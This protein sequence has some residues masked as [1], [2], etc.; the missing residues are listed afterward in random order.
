MTG[1]GNNV[2]PGKRYSVRQTAGVT[3]EA[4]PGSPEA[5]RLPAG[6]IVVCAE[7]KP[8][9]SGDPRVRISSPAGWMNAS[10]L[11]PAAPLEPHKLD[12]ETFLKC[13]LELAPGEFY[14]L[15]FPFTLE[16]LQDFGPKFL[17]AAFRA[18]NYLAQDNSVTKIVS[19]YSGLVSPCTGTVMVAL[20]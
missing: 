2:N 17:T 8:G 18:T 6:T 9:V 4:A 20:N 10:D 16:M 7:V 13:H 12:Y 11:Q 1:A 14:G 19:L 15:E 5:H 3:C